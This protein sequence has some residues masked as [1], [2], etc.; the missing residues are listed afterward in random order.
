MCNMNL[1]LCA[2]LILVTRARHALLLLVFSMFLD[3][4]FSGYYQFMPC[5]NPE[6]GMVDWSILLCCC[7]LVL[8]EEWWVVEPVRRKGKHVAARLYCLL[9]RFLGPLCPLTRLGPSVPPVPK[10]FAFLQL[11]NGNAS[12]TFFCFSLTYNKRWCTLTDFRYSMQYCL[13]QKLQHALCT[14]AKKKS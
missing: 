7:P 3:Q 5:M 9:Q 4:R 2:L 14:Q 6:E 10:T 8:E 11:E 13:Q 12:L 1:P